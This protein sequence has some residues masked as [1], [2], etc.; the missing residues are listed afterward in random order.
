MP[1]VIKQ[2]V[3]LPAAAKDLYAMYVDPKLHG[4]ITGSKVAIGARS[5]S[6]FRAFGGALSGHM[7]QTVPGRLIVQAWRSTQF[8]RGDM[9]STLIL[10]FAP[11]GKRGRI[12]LVHVNVP[13]HDYHGVNDGW[14]RYYWRPWRKY[15]KSR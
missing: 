2:S 15:L 1:R 13:D 6:K 3:V 14:K 9:D 4:A 12:D 11:A 8:R 10:R 7:L 5:G